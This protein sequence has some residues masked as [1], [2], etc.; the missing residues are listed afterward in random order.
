MPEIYPDDVE[1]NEASITATTIYPED[2]S[3]LEYELT[4]LSFE[5][6]YTENLEQAT[7]NISGNIEDNLVA[8]E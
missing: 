8:E 4:T 5:D 6:N 7:E 3:E 1:I 2:S